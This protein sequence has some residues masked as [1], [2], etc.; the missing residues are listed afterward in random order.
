MSTAVL[1][2]AHNDAAMK[3]EELRL[4]VSTTG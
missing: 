3:G 1:L 4:L 2:Y